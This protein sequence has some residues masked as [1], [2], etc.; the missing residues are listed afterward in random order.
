MQKF[1]K[2]LSILVALCLVVGAFAACGGNTG[3]NNDTTAP[4]TDAATPVTDGDAYVVGICQLVQHDALDAATKGFQEKLTELMTA[5]GKTVTFDYQNASG[6][7]ANCATI[8]NQFVANDVDLIMANATPALQAAATATV[9]SKT[10]VVAVAITDFGEALDI[11]MG[12]TDPTGINVTG[13]SDYVSSELQAQQILDLFPETKV[14]GCIY[15]S[16]EANSL[17]QVEGMKAAMAEKGVECNFYSFADTNDVQA[18][19]KKAAEES[20]VIYVPTDNTAASNGAIIADAC[21]AA[22]TPIVA[23][24]EGIFN[25]TQAV[26]TLTL[27]YYQNGVSAAE[28]AFEILVNGK[29]PAEMNIS[30]A[31]SDD[32]VYYYN[33]EMAEKYNV[34]VPENYVAYEAAAE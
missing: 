24:E 1:V 22:E 25:N 12:A 27:S 34:T 11:E 14:V 10:P 32:L 20:D 13:A 21:I 29:D 18:V 15:C 8:I 4:S 28:Q 31:E 5:A 26:A 6:E 3:D 30:Q 17:F 23:G 33:A 7:S 16:A 19:T 2:V 9:A